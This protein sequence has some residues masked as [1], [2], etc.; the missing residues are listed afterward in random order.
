MQVKAS[1][2]LLLQATFQEKNYAAILCQSSLSHCLMQ[3]SPFM[4]FTKQPYFH[5]VDSVK[6]LSANSK[7]PQNPLRVI[8]PN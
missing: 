2:C 7:Q 3:P 5:S 6:N 8:K 1:D 4:P